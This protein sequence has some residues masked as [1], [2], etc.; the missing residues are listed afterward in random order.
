MKKID[1]LPD[2]RSLD[3]KIYDKLEKL[4]KIAIKLAG[5]NKILKKERKKSKKKAKK[6]YKLNKK[7]GLLVMKKAKRQKGAKLMK[8]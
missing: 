1:K 6:R 4:E 2:E 3:E 8:R 7:T 5:I